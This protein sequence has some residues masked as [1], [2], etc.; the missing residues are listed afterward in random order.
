M[1]SEEKAAGSGTGNAN[2]SPAGSKLVL[3]LSVINLL[4]TFGMLA[5][6]FISFQKESH[7]TSVEDIAAHAPTSEGEHGKKPEEK[8]E[9]EGH[10]EGHAE[11]H[12]E[13]HGEGHGGGHKEE[14]KKKT[15]DYGKMVTLDQFTINLAT[16]GSMNP[17]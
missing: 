11:E 8:K 7:H 16:P 1:S 9:G 15:V 14:S 12:A 4:A 13:G 10:G 5:I 17:K 3:I 6:L 2:S